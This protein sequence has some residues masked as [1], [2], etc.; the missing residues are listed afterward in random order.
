MPFGVH[1]L[2]GHGHMT[3][4]NWQVVMKHPGNYY[5]L[6]SHFAKHLMPG[7]AKVEDVLPDKLPL[8]EAWHQE[9]A[10]ACHHYTVEAQNHID[11]FCSFLHLTDV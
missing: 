5:K 7:G 9:M 11:A 8:N 2:Y 6:R 1:L 10:P 3:S 4:V